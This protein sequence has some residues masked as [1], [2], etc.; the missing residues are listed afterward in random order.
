[1]GHCRPFPFIFVF[2]VQL[3]VNKYLL[4]NFCRRLDSNHGPLYPLSH[5]HCPK[6]PLKVAIVLE[7]GKNFGSLG[8]WFR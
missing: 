4:Y 2:S 5:N 3:T 8:W 6:L 7:S 1:M